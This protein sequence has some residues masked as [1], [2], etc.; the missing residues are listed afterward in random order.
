MIKEL[1]FKAGWGNYDFYN[2]MYFNIKICKIKTIQKYIFS[3]AVL[4]IATYNMCI[5]FKKIVMF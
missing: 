4:Q 5:L 1:N 3:N 2:K